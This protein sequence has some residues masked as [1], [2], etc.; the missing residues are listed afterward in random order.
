MTQPECRRATRDFPVWPAEGL[1]GRPARIV[2][3]EK[4]AFSIAEV[5]DALALQVLA[6]RITNLPDGLNDGIAALHMRR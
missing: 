2:G 3:R 4:F 1:M 6:Q 5:T